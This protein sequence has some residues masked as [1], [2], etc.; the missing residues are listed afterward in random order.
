MTMDLEKQ[1]RIFNGDL[2]KI[3]KSSN[4]RSNKQARTWITDMRFP[5]KP[6]KSA[7]VALSPQRDYLLLEEDHWVSTMPVF[8]LCI[9]KHTVQ[10]V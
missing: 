8:R 4:M 6:H 9:Q 5:A 3:R 1:G 7:K 2:I 10:A